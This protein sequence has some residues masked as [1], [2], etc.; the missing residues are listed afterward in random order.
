[1]YLFYL[2]HSTKQG[3]FKTWSVAV[4]LGGTDTVVLVGRHNQVGKEREDEGSDYESDYESEG[5]K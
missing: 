4:P 5:K 2:T 1:M 3:G